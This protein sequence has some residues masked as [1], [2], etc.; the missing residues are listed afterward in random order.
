MHKVT[1]QFRDVEGSWSDQE[2]VLL[3]VNGNKV[4][5]ASGWMDVRPYDH[6]PD[7]AVL[8]GHSLWR[9][10]VDAAAL[11]QIGVAI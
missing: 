1:G 7:T 5:S 11:R 6:D 4:R 3:E 10:H 9:W 8:V 2:L